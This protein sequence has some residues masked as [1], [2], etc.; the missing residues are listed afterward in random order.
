[1]I[2]PLHSRL[3]DST[4]P[5]LKKKKKSNGRREPSEETGLG[6][7]GHWGLFPSHLWSGPSSN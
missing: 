6:R 4:R 2:A 1:M 7:A 5:C 3:G